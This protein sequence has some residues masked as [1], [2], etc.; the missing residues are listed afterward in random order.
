MQGVAV[1]Q[2]GSGLEGWS[3][4]LHQFFS[5]GKHGTRLRPGQLNTF[6]PLL[7]QPVNTEK[8]WVY[9]QD[10][11]WVLYY[12]PQLHDQLSLELLCQMIEDYQYENHAKEYERLGG[13]CR[14]DYH[15]KVHSIEANGKK[16][17]RENLGPV[18]I[19]SVLL[20][21]QRISIG[22]H[23]HYNQSVFC[24]CKENGCNIF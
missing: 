12:N 24:C 4:P 17:Y 7:A 14:I 5:I 15:F 16:L 8:T 13:C 9:G 22:F 19:G 11:D 2:V 20:P 10:K 3:A 18:T 21:N 1:A 6:V 23:M